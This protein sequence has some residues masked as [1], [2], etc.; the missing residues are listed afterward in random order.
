LFSITSTS[1]DLSNASLLLPPFEKEQ[2]CGTKA[3]EETSSSLGRSYVTNSR[4]TLLLQGDNPKQSPP[5]NV[6]CRK[7]INFSENRLRYSTKKK[8]NSR[9]RQA[10]EDLLAG[11]R[12]GLRLGTNFC[13]GVGVGEPHSLDDF[14]MMKIPSSGT[15]RSCT[16]KTS[17][18]Q[19]REILKL[20]LPK[21]VF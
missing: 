14:L 11:K 10:N 13:K 9:S 19:R 20:N 15:K 8:C 5:L 16:P 2:H 12:S 4:H 3:F 17:P 21:D 1:K 6:L 7:R 18:K